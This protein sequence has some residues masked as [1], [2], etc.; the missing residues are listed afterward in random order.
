MVVKLLEVDLVVALCNRPQAWDCAFL[1]K[2]INKL[3]I[4]R[5]NGRDLI[6]WIKDN[7]ISCSF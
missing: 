1:E 3:N 5:V 2:E 6:I 4:L 7:N